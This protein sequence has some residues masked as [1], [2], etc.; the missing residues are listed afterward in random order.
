LGG[1]FESQEKEKAIEEYEILKNLDSELANKLFN[2][3]L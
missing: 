2:L 1:L 3:I